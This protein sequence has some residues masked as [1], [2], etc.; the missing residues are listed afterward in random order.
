MTE[1][2]DHDT[3]S[4]VDD[5]EPRVP[6]SRP[7]AAPIFV[8]DDEEGGMTAEERSALYELYAPSLHGEAREGARHRR[9]GSPSRNL[10]GP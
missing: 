6:S 7:M 2:R 1:E 3:H 9:Q 8:D 5:D 10:G 4:P